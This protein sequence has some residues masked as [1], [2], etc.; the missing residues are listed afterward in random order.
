MANDINLYLKMEYSPLILTKAA[1]ACFI[2][3]AYQLHLVVPFQINDKIFLQ[4][5]RQLFSFYLFAFQN[6]CQLV[7]ALILAVLENR[8]VWV[9]EMN[10]KNHLSEKI[11]ES[12]CLPEN[13]DEN[14]EYDFL[15][16]LVDM[17][18]DYLVE[19]N[20]EVFMEVQDKLIAQFEG[21]LALPFSDKLEGINR[22]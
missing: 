21:I 12:G 20:S 17:M 8:E 14:Q 19:V 22:A 4:L 16:I 6:S 7:N 15:I 1:K 11:L 5:D 13:H 9:H 2:F 10:E 18:I 3:Q